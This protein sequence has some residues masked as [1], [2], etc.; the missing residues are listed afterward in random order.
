M[1]KE[2]LVR[3]YLS[4]QMIKSGEKLIKKLD[5]K[6]AEVTSALWFFM[7]EERIWTLLIAS[8]LVSTGGPKQFYKKILEANRKSKV[9]ERI[10]SINN[11]S[12]TSPA[13]PLIQVINT[14]V[15][16]DAKSINSIRFS[17]NT[18]NGVFIEDCHIYRSSR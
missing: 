17:R 4:P 9:S 10:I 5:E 18:F 14:M 12:V 6:G 3:D 8:P 2:L 1:A 13:E 16:T 7:A 15:S 11:I